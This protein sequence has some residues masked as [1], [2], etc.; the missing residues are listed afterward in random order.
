MI[1]LPNAISHAEVASWNRKGFL[2]GPWW[3]L[4][5]EVLWIWAQGGLVVCFWLSSHPADTEERLFVMSSCHFCFSH[6]PQRGAVGK[7]DLSSE[8]PVCEAVPSNLSDLYAAPKDDAG[9]FHT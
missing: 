9:V 4:S 5:E 1:I 6:V 7:K 8:S 2:W 3:V